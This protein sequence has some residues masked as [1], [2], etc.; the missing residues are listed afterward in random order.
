M[1]KFNGSW[2]GSLYVFRK[3]KKQMPFWRKITNS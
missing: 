1:C 2:C 3:A